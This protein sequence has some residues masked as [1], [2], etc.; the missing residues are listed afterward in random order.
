MSTRTTASGLRPADDLRHRPIA[1]ERTRDSLFWQLTMPE[2]ELA[3]QIY[4]YLTG[5]GKAGYNICV[6]RS[7]PQPLAAQQHSGTIPDHADLD[8][9]S[10]GGLTR[11]QPDPRRTCRLTYDRGGVRIE[12]DFTGSVQLS[13]QP[14]WSARVVRGEQ[15]RIDRSCPRRHR[16]AGSHH[17]LGPHRSSRPLVGCARL[18]RTSALEMTDR[19]HRVRPCG[20][21]VDLDSHGRMGL[22]RIRRPGRHHVPG[23]TYRAAHRI[24]Q[25]DAPTH[26]ASDLDGYL[27]CPNTPGALGH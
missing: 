22:R 16:G 7:D 23:R 3:M 13:L 17:H 27:R 6:W 9:F 11:S 4:L 8:E 12:Y 21:R 19:L 5:S 1:G 26:R 24:R 20:E 10:F 15:N 25:H 18:G 14:R 2:E